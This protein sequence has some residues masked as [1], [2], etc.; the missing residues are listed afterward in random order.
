MTYRPA[1]PRKAGS[2]DPHSLIGASPET[3]LI[4]GW[5]DVVLSARLLD[6]ADNVMARLG[7]C[8][9][10]LRGHVVGDADPAEEIFQRPHQFTDPETGSRL[11]GRAESVRDALS[12]LTCPPRQL[13]PAPP[14]RLEF[15]HRT[16]HLASGCSSPSTSICPASGKERMGAAM[17]AFCLCLSCRSCALWRCR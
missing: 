5:S 2:A 12:A 9:R 4:R 7:R 16:D 14:S 13:R 10:G 15:H 11:A 17:S 8:S 6:D 3:G 1:M